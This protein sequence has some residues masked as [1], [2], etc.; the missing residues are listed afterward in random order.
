MKNDK[1]HTEIDFWQSNTDLMSAF[2]LMMLLLI[3]LLI[4]YLMQIPENISA[5]GEANQGFLV[6]DEL[7]DRTDE[8]YH[9]PAE[10]RRSPENIQ[11]ARDR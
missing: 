2:A 3:M 11:R 8:A 7:G 6:D 10:G 5:D 4:L 9:Y 1:N